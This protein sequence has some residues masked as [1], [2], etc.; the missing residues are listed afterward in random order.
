MGSNPIPPKEVIPNDTLLEVIDHLKAKCPV[1][2]A[3]SA[4]AK[5]F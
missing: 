2:G 3:K 1:I 4:T 5:E